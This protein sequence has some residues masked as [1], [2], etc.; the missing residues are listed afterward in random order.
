MDTIGFVQYLAKLGKLPQETEGWPAYLQD[1]SATAAGNRDRGIA[2]DARKQRHLTETG[3]WMELTYF[4]LRTTIVS[5]INI[6]HS[7]HRDVEGI[8]A[9]FTLA[10][11]L[12]AGLEGE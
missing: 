6:E 5:Y 1:G 11:D 7:F 8:T 10:H 4:S 2:L 9:P 12:F 3:A